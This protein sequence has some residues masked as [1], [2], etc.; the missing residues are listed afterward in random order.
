MLTLVLAV[1]AF[2]NIRAL[3]IMEPP[4]V[5][6]TLA[7]ALVVLMIIPL[8][9]R[10]IVPSSVLLTSTLAAV[11]LQIFNILEGNFTV[12]VLSTLMQYTAEPKGT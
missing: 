9:W 6:V 8:I 5:H 7:I 10:R 3:W 1:S 11:I 4:S 2:I 12:I